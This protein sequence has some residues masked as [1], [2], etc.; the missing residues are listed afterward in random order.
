[1]ISLF[2]GRLKEGEN[3]KMDLEEIKFFPLKAT[4]FTFRQIKGINQFI[5]VL[6]VSAF[7]STF[8]FALITPIFAVFLTGQVEGGTLIVVG[9]AE[10]IYL[11]TKSVFQIPVSL[12]LDRTPGERVDFYCLFL[13]GLLITMVPFFYL[14]VHLSW[15]VYVLQFLHGLG[16]ALDWPAWMGLF[17]RHIDQN[18]ESFEWSF[19][20]TLGEIGMALAALSGGFVADRFGFRPVFMMMGI[21]SFL[22]FLILMIFYQKIKKEIHA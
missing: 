4:R 15:Q 10:T 17:T 11:V 1:M 22:T 12:L 14:F 19:Q 7:T 3:I 16:A 18:R 8:S 5:W 21:F 9:L 2:P 13:G 20:T 6:I